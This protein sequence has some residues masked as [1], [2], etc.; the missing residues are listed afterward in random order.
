MSSKYM[1]SYIFNTLLV[2]LLN[3]L[4]LQYSVVWRQSAHGP[5][6]LLKP[7]LL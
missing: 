1:F 4:L 5:A 3:E 6:V 7:E 2:V